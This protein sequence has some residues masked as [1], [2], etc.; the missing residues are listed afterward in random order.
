MGGVYGGWVQVY[1]DG[2]RAESGETGF[3][4]AVPERGIGM[5]RRTTDGLGVH[6]VEM[7]VVLVALRW[8]ECSRVGRV[9]VCSDSASV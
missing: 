2:W 5:N 9:V 7:V 3:G 6:T 4:V 8:V 1:I